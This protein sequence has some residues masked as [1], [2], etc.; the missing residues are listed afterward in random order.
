MSKAYS[1]LRVSGQSQLAGDGYPRQRDAIDRYAVRADITIAAEFAEPGVSGTNELEDRPALSELIGRI[2]ENGVRLVVVESADRLA[3]DLMVQETILAQFR[4][5]GVAVVD[6]GGTDLTVADGD[7]T[8]KLIRQVLGAVAEF[9]KST[10]VRKLRAA[11]KRSG[12]KEGR[13]PYGEHPGER[14]VLDRIKRLRRKPR[15]G[16]RMPCS[17]IAVILNSEN[18]MQRNGKPWS[19]QGIENIVG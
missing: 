19:R 15:L 13:K 16:T 8:R 10:L 12:C 11:R 18:I 17:K 6:S 3:R 5:L 7:P 4:K 14:E 1:Y 2:A 9:E